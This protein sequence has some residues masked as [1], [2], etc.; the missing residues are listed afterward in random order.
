MNSIRQDSTVT[1]SEPP[2]SSDAERSAFLCVVH[3]PVASVVGDRI[4]IR[5][6]DKATAIGRDVG[7]AGTSIPDPWMSRIHFRI[8]FDRRMHAFRLG[9][10]QSRNGT[11]LNGEKVDTQSLSN[12]NVI[13]GGDTLFVFEERNAMAQVERAA[14]QAARSQLPILLCGE[15]GA[16]K[17]R[18]AQF[19]HERSQ[20]PGKFVP[21]NC[22]VL[23]R[24][25]LASELF[26]HVKGAFSGAGKS[27]EGLVARAHEGTLFLDEIGDLPL[28]QQPAL[29]RVLQEGTVRPIGSDHEVKVDLRVVS[30]TNVDLQQA[31]QAGRFRE[32][33]FG[34][35]AHLVL[36]LPPLRERKTEILVIAEQIGTLPE[37]KFSYDADAA[38]CLLLWDWPRNIRELQ[39]LVHSLNVF[40][41][42]PPFNLK[43]LLTVAPA[44]AGVLA[45]RKKL[46]AMP[47]EAPPEK[48]LGA[49]VSRKKLRKLLEENQ[50]NLASVSK[51]LG[52]HRTEVYRWLEKYGL[53]AEEFR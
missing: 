51:Q 18:M 31:S 40:S 52:I 46:P 25:L 43:H 1:R 17:E 10:A 27:R 3:S 30:A 7:K 37:H 42:E 21:V 28:D 20:R 39:S 41:Q 12:G 50:G 34:R 13:R 35:L 32:D 53:D 36:E 26:G 6:H 15:T 45:C 29:L 22:A 5:S 19:I 4:P 14:E 47:S 23:P 9:D 8:A 44:V 16:G 38:E 49:T 2:P 48:Q 33:L 11:W 24:D